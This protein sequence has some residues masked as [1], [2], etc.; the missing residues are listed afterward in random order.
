MSK[1]NSVAK[2]S[3]RYPWGPRTEETNKK[4]AA[5]VAELK[6][7]GLSEEE[8]LKMLRMDK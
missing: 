4:L 2:D 7:A 8:A 5:Y 3:G 6:E 1:E